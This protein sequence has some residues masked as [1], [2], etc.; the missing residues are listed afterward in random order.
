[1]N[2]A[3][4]NTLTGKCKNVLCLKENTVLTNFRYNFEQVLQVNYEVEYY[5]F[6]IV[7]YS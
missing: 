7:Q 1:M 3:V 4:M 2:V 5:I 6:V